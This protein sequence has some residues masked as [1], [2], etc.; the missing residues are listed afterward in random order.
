[1]AGISR[2]KSNIAEL[3][4]ELQDVQ[5][6]VKTEI[7]AELI[8]G[9]SVVVDELA[10]G[11]IK[12]KIDELKNQHEKL[13]AILFQVKDDKVMMAAGVKGCDA[14]AGDWIKHIAPL[15]GGGGGGRAD[16]AQ[17]GGKDISKLQEA[18]AEALKFIT[19]VLS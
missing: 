16:F 7:K 12:E 2:L 10:N 1:M 11:D 19:E 9:V 4:K 13:C 14:K 15:L 17:A 18:K 6:S 3:K 8:N 5:N